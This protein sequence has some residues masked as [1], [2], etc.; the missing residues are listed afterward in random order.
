[1]F[2]KIKKVLS[3]AALGVAGFMSSSVALAAVDATAVV[4]EVEA[5]G[6]AAKLVAV[7]VMLVI[8]G[9]AAFKYIRRAIS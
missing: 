8:V 6:T 1:M 5:A 7:A 9:I 2:T 3:G 4:T